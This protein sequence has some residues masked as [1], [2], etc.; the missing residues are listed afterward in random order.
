MQDAEQLDILLTEQLVRGIGSELKVGTLMVVGLL[1][2]ALM[3]MR[4]V[5]PIRAVAERLQD[6]SSGEEI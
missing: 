6:I 2:V 4:L 3:A 5:R 1:V